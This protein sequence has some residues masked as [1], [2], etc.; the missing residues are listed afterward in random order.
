MIQI[1]LELKDGARRDYR[2][3]RSVVNVGRSPLNDVEVEDRAVSVRHGV[4]RLRDGRLAF[5]DRDSLGGTRLER[6][7]GSS[8]VHGDCEVAPGDVLVLGGSARLVILD[9]EEH[10]TMGDRFRHMAWPDAGSVPERA[11]SVIDT[12]T[13]SLL[14]EPERIRLING[15][16]AVFAAG[17]GAEILELGTL[18]DL[19]RMPAVSMLSG[20]E[21]RPGALGV[22]AADHERLLR[23]LRAGGLVHHP[24]RDGHR[25]YLGGPSGGKDNDD[26]LVIHLRA[27]GYAEQDLL[28]LGRPLAAMIAA[29]GRAERTLEHITAVE[30]ENRYFKDRQRRHYLFKEL[31]TESPVMKRLYHRLNTMV[32]SSGPVLLAGEAGTGKQMVARALHHLGPR[33]AGLLVTGRCGG[34]DGALAIELFGTAARGD[35]PARPGIFELADGGTVYLDELARMPRLLQARLVRMIQEGEIR[36]E[37]EEVA[38][39]VDVRL[40]LATHH[41]S[42]ELVAAGRV[43]QDLFGALR[44]NV[45]TVPPLRERREDILPLAKLFAR[46]FAGR[47]GSGEPVF[48]SDVGEVLWHHPWRGN[49]RELQ[50]AV[51]S[52]VLKRGGE[53]LR[54]ADF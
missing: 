45:L 15:A 39:R 31:V 48:A 22:P 27:T 53:P 40:V 3:S 38:R 12:L 2:F 7:G 25:L 13:E 21:L 52:A 34:D 35:E 20:G 23:W 47:Y 4:L 43:R 32:D 5:E 33:Q 44:D 16:A 41:D 50:S 37:G 14:V 24:H 8:D 49:V 10:S 9:A 51:E 18:R 42:E 29:V 46:V 54:G 1:R 26:A 36:R 19:T 17:L 30:A 28:D 11:R 6:G